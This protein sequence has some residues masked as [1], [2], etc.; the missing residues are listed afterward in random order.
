[1]DGMVIPLPL[2]I[3]AVVVLMGGVLGVWRAR[4][5]GAKRK[6]FASALLLFAIA[7]VGYMMMIAGW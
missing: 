3:L 2:Q 6:W 1:M 5:R 4:G 7:A